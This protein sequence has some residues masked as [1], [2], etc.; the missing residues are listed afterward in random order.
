VNSERKCICCWA[1]SYVWSEVKEE[2]SNQWVVQWNIRPYTLLGGFGYGGVHFFVPTV[3]RPT[4]ISP[5]TVA[6]RPTS[7]PTTV[8]KSLSPP[9]RLP[10]MTVADV[11]RR[12]GGGV[13]NLIGGASTNANEGQSTSFDRR[14]HGRH[15]DRTLLRLIPRNPDGADDWL[16]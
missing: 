4:C 8:V 13:F 1:V 16:C 12:M 15:S 11:H 5:L 6:S 9:T 3:P 10:L 14:L 7:P 2:R